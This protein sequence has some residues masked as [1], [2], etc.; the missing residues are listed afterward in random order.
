MVMVREEGMMERGWVARE[1]S[2]GDGEG[3][4]DDGERVGGEGGKCW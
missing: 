3:G 2:V 1:G 4:R